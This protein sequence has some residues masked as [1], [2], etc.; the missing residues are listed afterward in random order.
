MPESEISGASS[1]NSPPVVDNALY[2]EINTRMRSLRDTE[3]KIITFF[4]QICGIVVAA[5]SFL[6]G[7][8]EISSGV[9]FVFSVF[10]SV[11]FT[12]FYFSVFD[13]VVYDAKLYKSLSGSLKEN[14]KERQSLIKDPHASDDK[15]T[16]YVRN[17]RI[18]RLSYLFVI[19]VVLCSSLFKKEE[20]PFE[21][22]GKKEKIVKKYVASNC[23]SVVCFVKKK[24][25]VPQC[26]DFYKKHRFGFFFFFLVFLL[27]LLMLNGKL[28]SFSQMDKE[29]QTKINELYDKK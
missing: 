28:C 19:V 17:L 3:F 11:F 5:N 4:F 25:T 15:V 8:S 21:F 29:I 12:M 6:L 27:V 26:L 18:L 20:S 9:Y 1:E 13:R 10:F 2:A 22:S 24:E 16:G 14:F 23:L 7:S